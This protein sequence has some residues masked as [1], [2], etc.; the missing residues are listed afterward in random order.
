M[1]NAQTG[2]ILRQLQKLNTPPGDD[3]LLNEQLLARFLRHKDPEAFAALVRRHGSLVLN[4]CRSVLRQQQDAEDVFQATFLVLARNAATIQKQASVA[5]WLH[6]VAFRL[7][8]KA[9]AG[10]AKRR[11]HEQQAGQKPEAIAGEDMSWRDVQR[12][13]HEEVNR[14]PQKQRTPLLL[15]Y[16]EAKTQDEAARQLGIPKG[17]LKERLERARDILRGRLSRRGVDL[18]A[19]LFAVLLG[20]EAALAVPASLVHLAAQSAHLFA[21]GQ[22]AAGALSANALALADGACQAMAVTKTK[23]AVALLF[24]S[25]LIAAGA[26]ALAQPKPD[27][28]TQKAVGALALD[29]IAQPPDDKNLVHAN[30]DVHGDPLPPGALLR[31][32]TVRFRHGETICQVAFS[33]NGKYLAS[34]SQNGESNA[35]PNDI[36]LWDR[37]TGKLIHRFGGMRQDGIREHILTLA[38][39]PDSKL[40]ATQNLPGVIR[41]WEAATGKEIREIKGNVEFAKSDGPG[42][43]LIGAGCVFSPDGKHLA[44]RGADKVIHLWEVATGKNVRAF[45]GHPEDQSPIAFSR[46]GATLAVS[47]DTWIRLWNTHTG[48]EVGKLTGHEGPAGGGAFSL[49]N[50]TF[51]AFTSS[52]ENRFGV[53]VFVWDVAEGKVLHNSEVGRKGGLVL[54]CTLSPDL[55]TALVGGHPTT[56]I[57]VATGREIRRF[58]RLDSNTH[59]LAFS[60]D[61][62]TVAE[63]GNNRTVQLWNAETGAPL[64]DATGHSGIVQSLSLSA[65]GKTL[66]SVAADRS[67]W[68]WDATTGKSRTRI[69]RAGVSFT[70]AI[71]SPNGVT[72]AATAEDAFVR[73][74]ETATG[75]E[76]R[77]LTGKAP[78]RTAAFSP[79]GKILAAGGGE[80]RVWLWDADTGKKLQEF[81]HPRPRESYAGVLGLAFSPDGRYLASAGWGE[82]AAVW[83][84]DTGKLWRQLPGHDYWV[85]SLSFS[86]DGTT[87]ATTGWDKTIR[88]W[89]LATGKI[90]SRFDGHSDRLAVVAFSPDGLFLASGSDD[91]TVR[92]WDVSTGQE[93]GRFLGHENVVGR[94]CFAADGKTLYSGSW[95]TT[96]LA[97]DMNMLAMKRLPTAKLTAKDMEAFWNDLAS[98][99]APK[100]GQAIWA[101]AADGSMDFL[102]KQLRPLE[103]VDGKRLARLIDDLDSPQFEVRQRAAK[104]LEALADLAEPAL[105]KALSGQPTLEAR[106]RL[107]QLLDKLEGPITNPKTLQELRAVEVLE[108]IGGSEAKQLLTSLAAGA[109]EAWLTREVRLALKRLNRKRAAN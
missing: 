89:E 87:L 95:D 8:Q 30:S 17:T 72:L 11:L 53:R 73:L 51:A 22:N 90:R 54:S 19:A 48:K 42:G 39:S 88:L 82:F 7:A 59:A 108:K 96:I 15:C 29:G 21:A 20:R 14:L 28:Q 5:S 47:G 18:S 41:L 40:L 64:A 97:W 37:A 32:G 66:A 10:A 104:V 34:A 109:P 99:E 75:K 101:F 1:N 98:E 36:C 6:G 44:A 55:K 35:N 103:P 86:P 57:D 93:L 31:F 43:R 83:E 56:Q 81:T 9:K 79:D 76:I 45:A 105:R 4:V 62:K 77:R 16:W 78:V 63:A 68:L 3:R 49:D 69:E 65:D 106:Q 92:I 12:V 2:V 38:F 27:A 50:K 85:S 13:L 100:A 61:G 102:K 80:G 84:V 46:D 71:F 33:P 25:T 26:G 60:P 52:L 70:S 107:K 74:L 67:I 23:L 58:A 94:L 91:K 24:L